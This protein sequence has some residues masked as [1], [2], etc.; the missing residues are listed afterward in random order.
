MSEVLRLQLPVFYLKEMPVLNPEL[1]RRLDDVVV[2]L[3]DLRDSL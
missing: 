1:R 2:R 3:T